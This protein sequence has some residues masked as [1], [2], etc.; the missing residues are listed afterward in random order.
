M[1]VLGR[2]ILYAVVEILILD[3]ALAA[4]KGYRQGQDRAINEELRR[5]IFGKKSR[6]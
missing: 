2:R 6:N 3:C 1:S 5:D 4:I